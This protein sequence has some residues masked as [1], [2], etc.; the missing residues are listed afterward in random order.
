MWG[1]NPLGMK[2]PRGI[3]VNVSVQDAVVHSSC[4]SLKSGLAKWSKGQ[5]SCL[6]RAGR[7]PV[8]RQRRQRP[9]SG[10][11]GAAADRERRSNRSGGQTGAAVKQERRSKASGLSG[12]SRTDSDGRQDSDGRIGGRPSRN[13]GGDEADGAEAQP[14]VKSGLVRWSNGQ[15]V[16]WSNGQRVKGSNGQMVKWLNGQMPAR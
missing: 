5:S 9:T 7:Q 1:D 6:S 11:T 8:R 10:Q 14:V 13:R 12:P 2:M 4:L 3:E 16:K 15:M